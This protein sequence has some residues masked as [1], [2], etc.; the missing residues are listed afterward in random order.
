VYADA[1]AV[2]APLDDIYAVTPLNASG[3]AVRTPAVRGW[4]AT[5]ATTLRIRNVKPE[6]AARGYCPACDQ[7]GRNTRAT[8]FMQ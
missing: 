7:A 3:M 6:R 8:P 2:D 5:R 1:S 4:G